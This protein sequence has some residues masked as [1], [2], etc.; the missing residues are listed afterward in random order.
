MTPEKINEIRQN[1][2]VA[3]LQKVWEVTAQIGM[4]STADFA[5]VKGELTEAHARISELED[6]YEPKPAAKLEAVET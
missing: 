1:A 3:F 6:K 5:Q 2:S 4:N